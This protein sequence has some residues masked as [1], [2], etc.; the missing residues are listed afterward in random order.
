MKNW[1]VQC[2]EV[3]SIGAQPEARGA[4]NWGLRRTNPI[5]MG[6]NGGLSIYIYTCVCGGGEERG[7]KNETE[8]GRERRGE[9]G[10]ERRREEESVEEREEETKREEKR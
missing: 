1:S 4:G 9:G 6:D 5:I 3:G 10:R 2:Q 7:R 8:R